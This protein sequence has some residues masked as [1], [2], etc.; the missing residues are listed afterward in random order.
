MERIR[1]KAAT[2]GQDISGAEDA[3]HTPHFKVSPDEV[4]DLYEQWV[5]PMTKDV[6]VTYLLQRLDAEA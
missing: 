1:R 4:A 3:S 6:Q 5:M 2:F